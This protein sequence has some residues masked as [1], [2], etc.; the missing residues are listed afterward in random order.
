MAFNKA[1]FS[2]IASL[3]SDL[4]AIWVYKTA[5]A[6][7]VVNDPGYFPADIGLNLGD[8][9]YRITVNSLSAPTSVTSA[10]L[11]VVT[12]VSATEVQVSSATNIAVAE[13][14]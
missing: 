14:D 6:A 2:P 3:G 11:H 9:V 12:S 7:T 10:G 1:Y 13:S 5:D 8:L 4:P